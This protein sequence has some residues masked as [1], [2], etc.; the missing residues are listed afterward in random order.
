MLAIY[1]GVNCLAVELRVRGELDERKRSVRV[2]RKHPERDAGHSPLKL[3]KKKESKGGRKRTRTE[4][5]D[6]G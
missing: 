2:V 4:N 6:G 5:E 3:R 1:A